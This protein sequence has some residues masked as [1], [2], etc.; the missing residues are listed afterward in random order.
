MQGRIDNANKA[1][2][3]SVIDVDTKPVLHVVVAPYTGYFK[4]V[5]ID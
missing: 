2:A 5:Y 4:Q 1:H 3:V